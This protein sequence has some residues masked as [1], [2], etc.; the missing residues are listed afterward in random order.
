[1]KI[2]QINTVYNT[3]S[4]GRIVEQ[5]KEAIETGGDECMIAYGRGTCVNDKNT[6]RITPQWDIYAHA[7]LTRITDKTGFFSTKFTRKLCKKIVEFDP[8]I[9]HL[10]NLHGYYLNV[11][12]LFEF[13]KSYNKPVM[14]TLHD[15]WPFTGHCAYFT[16]VKCNQWKT[17]CCKCVQKNRYPAS[18]WLDNSQENYDRKQAAFLGVSDMTIITPSYWLKSLVKESF[19]KVY[20]VKVIQNGV[21]LKQFYPMKSDFR[22]KYNIENKFLILGVSNAWADARKGY[23]DFVKLYQK[24]NDECCIVLVGMTERELSALPQGLIGIK[25]TN[26]I[27]ELAEIYSSADLFLNLTYEDNYP[28]VNLEALACGTPVLTYDSGGSS[29]SVHDLEA[30]ADEQIIDENI[31]ITKKGFIVKTGNVEAV[32]RCI[33]TYKEHLGMFT[34]EKDDNNKVFLNQNRFLE[35]YCKLYKGKMIN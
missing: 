35:N 28:S 1:M 22:V 30:I 8:D 5:I 33:L 4:T 21:N 16:W 23:A 25:K 19:L 2:F 13:L 17:H 9:I 11:E 32:Y 12:V 10:H 14:W 26:S 34:I 29:E 6:Y 24:L 18:K 3:G 15:C 27:N 20:P 31:I 7:L